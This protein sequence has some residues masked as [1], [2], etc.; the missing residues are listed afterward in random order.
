MKG[1]GLPQGKDLAGMTVR[2]MGLTVEGEV[3]RGTSMG[4]V[5]PLYYL[6]VLYPL[7][8]PPLLTLVNLSG[9]HTT[10]PTQLSPLKDA[11]VRA[12]G[13]SNGDDE[14]EEDKLTRKLRIGLRGLWRGR[15][16]TLFFS[17]LLGFFFSLI[18]SSLTPLL[19]HCQH[20]S[21]GAILYCR[22]LFLI[23]Q[24]INTLHAYFFIVSFILTLLH[25]VT[26]PSRRGTSLPRCVDYLH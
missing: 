21:F 15:V 6:R 7:L 23:S 12:G 16:G 9:P 5:K 1:C 2:L 18:A 25:L 13:T 14:P 4:I 26:C 19:F 24:E 20:M 17:C 3:T 22:T 10:T 11:V 8:H